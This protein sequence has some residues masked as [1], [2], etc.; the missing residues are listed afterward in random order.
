MPF[1]SQCGVEL[2]DDVKKCP[3]CST[4]VFKASKKP[5]GQNQSFPDIPVDKPFPM[6]MEPKKMRLFVWEVMSI[7]LLTP[8]LITLLTNIVIDFDITWSRFPLAVL[9][10]V[11]LG[12]TIPI[13]LYRIPALVVLLETF[14]LLGFLSGIDYLVDWKMDWFL[15]LAL[16]IVIIVVFSTIVA[17]IPSLVVKKKGANIASFILF[18]IGVCTCGLD[19]VISS[20]LYHKLGISWSLYVMIPVTCT[21]LFLLYIHYRG[22]KV[23]D[24]VRKKLQF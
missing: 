22:K 8:L 13:F 4:P 6:T 20:N 14:L 5:A 18:G 12:A 10:L 16:P 17:V 21:G 11:W 1:C 19:F 15:P 24:V 3:L 9:S 2:D 7:C 23:L